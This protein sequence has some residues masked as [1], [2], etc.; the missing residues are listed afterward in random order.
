MLGTNELVVLVHKNTRHISYPEQLR[1]KLCRVR[2]RQE[3]QPSIVSLKFEV[4][5]TGRDSHRQLI[6]VAVLAPVMTYPAPHSA[7]GFKALMGRL[8]G[9]T[10]PA[11]GVVDG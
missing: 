7:T 10:R 2:E 4:I 1:V 9:E 5:I 6:M 8:T 11:Y 3:C